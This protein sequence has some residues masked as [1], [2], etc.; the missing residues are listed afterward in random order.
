MIGQE[1]LEVSKPIETEF[2]VDYPV[3]ERFI[4]L[5]IERYLEVLDIT[6]NRAQNAII[7][8]VNDPRYRFITAC[9]SRR[10]G[11]TFISNIIG[12][13]VSLYPNSHVLIISPNYNLSGISWDLQRGFLT[14][15]DIELVRSN[16]KDKVMELENGSSIR[17][18]SISQADSVSSYLPP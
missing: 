16:A 18:G 8:A 5:P 1:P 15:F 7:N 4:K 11:K 17:M 12:N 13:L 14:K 3:P 9:V 2:I 10:V 6:P